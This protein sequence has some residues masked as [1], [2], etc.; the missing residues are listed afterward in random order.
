MQT[1]TSHHRRCTKVDAHEG[2]GVR[3]EACSEQVA[4]ECYYTLTRLI[5]SHIEIGEYDN[6]VRWAGYARKAMPGRA[7]FAVKTAE[8]YYRAR[9]VE[10]FLSVA[11]AL[12][13]VLVGA[14]L[15]YWAP[16]LHM[17]KRLSPDHNLFA[18]RNTRSVSYSS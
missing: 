2:S 1:L 4:E 5:D 9:D 3:L 17:G 12:K 13:P 7:E 15:R 6:A 18:T 11:T 8:I 16:I 14:N 10:G